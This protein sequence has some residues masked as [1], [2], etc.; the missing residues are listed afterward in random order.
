MMSDNWFDPIEARALVGWP[1]EALTRHA[2]GGRMQRGGFATLFVIFTVLLLALP[3]SPGLAASGT[4]TKQE[5]F[6]L[7][8]VMAWSEVS[9]RAFESLKDALGTDGPQDAQWRAEV[10]KWLAVWPAVYDTAHAATPPPSLTGLHDDALMALDDLVQASETI[11]RNLDERSPALVAKSDEQLTRGFEGLS[12]VLD[13]VSIFMGYV[14]EPNGDKPDT[15]ADARVTPTPRLRATPTPEPTPTVP[16]RSSGRQE[17]AGNGDGVIDGVMLRSGLVRI[18][19]THEGDSNFVVWLYDESGQP[20]DL[21]VNEIGPYQGERAIPIAQSG[22]YVI[23]V[24]ADG[25]WSIIV[26]Q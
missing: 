12:K 26:E 1:R 25:A 2:E 15:D 22:E 9:V 24:Q 10:M 7:G 3:A 5:A 19:A 17:F 16:A 6:F 14:D 20:V 11:E 21:V 8:R 18:S 23:G 4:P 13:Q